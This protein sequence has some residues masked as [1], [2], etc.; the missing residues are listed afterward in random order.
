[1]PLIQSHFI[2]FHGVYGICV[3]VNVETM[4]PLISIWLWWGKSQFPATAFE[5]ILFIHLILYPSLYLNFTHSWLLLYL[6]LDHTFLIHTTMWSTMVKVIETKLV[7]DHFNHW[8]WSFLPLIALCLQDQGEAIAHTM[9][10]Q[11]SNARIEGLK[12]GTSYVVQVRAR[13]VAGYGRYSSPAHFSTNLQSMQL[14][15]ILHYKGIY[16]NICGL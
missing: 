16:C 13:T 1:M 6:S 12:A 11:R 10:A 5:L 8:H 2:D 3:S 7:I 15:N 4:C 14:S 9:T